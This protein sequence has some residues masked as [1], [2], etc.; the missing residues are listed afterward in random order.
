M[1]IGIDIRPM[2][3]SPRTGVGEYTFELLDAVF[4]IDQNNQYFL[5]YNASKQTSTN[6][7]TWN[8][9]N[10]HYVITHY[11]NK[12]FNSA[13][14]LLSR[15]RLDK[16]ISKKCNLT[17]GLDCFYSPNLN[18]V[19]LSSK[20]KYIL[21]IH[22][23][24]FEFFPEFFSKKQILWHGAVNP[25]KQCQRADTILAPSENTKRDIMNYYKIE[26]KKIKVIYP[27]LSPIFN[28]INNE[29][30]STNKESVK[31]KYNLPNHY[32]LFL[33]TIEPRK[34]IV[35]LIEAFEK[36]YS[37]LPIPHHLIIAGAN[38][39]SNKEIF[40]RAAYSPIKDHIKFIGYINSEDKPALYSN[41][42]LFIYPSFYEGFG[43][44]ALEAM[45]M[46]AP[47]ITSNRSSLL[48]VAGDA[49]Y[50]INPLQTNSI[51]QAIL[52]ILNKPE[53]RAR[54]IK[55]G[56]ERAQLFSWEKAAKEWI[57]TIT[58]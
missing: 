26:E 35:G 11:P 39:W 13:I 9:P 58:N 23:L 3:T 50:L 37:N 16:I 49:A 7:P 33:G 19:S 54:L 17:N 4:K 47:V 40:N 57:T 48:E 22:D 27:G 55:K 56:R 46:G 34:N 15:P 14:K 42:S 32:I 28:S 29:Q 45:A 8:Q 51:I 44:P 53:L 38:G 12:L 30:L 6:L 18:F 31:Q 5:Y 21:T 20:T 43:F 10:V 52:D 1:N 36:V 41:A 24:S 25:K 2:M